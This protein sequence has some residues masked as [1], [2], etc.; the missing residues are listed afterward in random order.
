M[1]YLGIHINDK[2][3]WS[4]QCQFAASKATRVLNVLRRTMLGC[5]SE[6]KYRAYKA[7][8]RPLLEYACMVWSP[9]AVKDVKLFRGVLHGGF[10]AVVGTKLR[11][12]GLFLMM[13][14]MLTIL[15]C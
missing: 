7:I 3:Q 2:L 9:H 8:V 6:A 13:C 15:I 1:K 14:A 12:L 4:S 5:D 11:T 10:V